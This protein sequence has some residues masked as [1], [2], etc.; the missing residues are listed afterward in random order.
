MTS[1]PSKISDILEAVLLVRT[2]AWYCALPIATVS[3]TCRPLPIQPVDGVPVFV[4]GVTVVR[5]LTAPVLHLGMLLAGGRAEPG[6]RFVM[7]RIRDRL[8]VLEVDETL[9]VRWLSRTQLASASPLVG[10]ALSDRIDGIG[11]LDGE[12]LAWLDTA[13]LVQN[14]L[15]DLVLSEGWA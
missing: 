1:H 4:R 11:V 3:E 5:G 8:G 15:L 12:L 9:G 2:Q 14:D 6:R 7:V 10:G 13:R